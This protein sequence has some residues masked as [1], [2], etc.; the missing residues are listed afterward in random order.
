M[1]A[2][3][4]CREGSSYASRFP[5][6]L[7]EGGLPVEPYLI[8]IKR[9]GPQIELFF[10]LPAKTKVET[11]AIKCHD[12]GYY[13]RNFLFYFNRPL[14]TKQTPVLNW[15]GVFFQDLSPSWLLPCYSQCFRVEI[16]FW[17]QL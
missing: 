15:H 12:V 7:A 17:D 2:L 4:F 1:S 9:N 3:T 13:L 8:Y 16:A 6:E 10:N 5:Q 14:P 11:T